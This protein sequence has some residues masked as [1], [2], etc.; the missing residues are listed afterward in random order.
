MTAR[1]FQVALVDGALTIFG[2]V[3]LG[4]GLWA[5][6]RENLG[7]AGTALGGGL[8]LVFGATIHRFESLKGL[9]MEAKTRK[10]DETID[11]AEVALS[12]LKELTELVGANLIK[13]SSSI[14]RFSGAPSIMEAYTLSRQV[15]KTLDGINADHSV[16]QEALEPW[17]KIAAVDLFFSEHEP[18]RRIVDQKRQDLSRAAAQPAAAGA[19]A[20]ALMSR[21][22]EMESY[23]SKRFTEI[24]TWRLDQF[25][26]RL[27]DRLNTAPELEEDQRRLF[28]VAFRRAAEQLDALARTLDFADLAYWRAV[29]RA[30]EQ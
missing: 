8:I 27:F 23:L 1:S 11:K 5:V 28:D 6:W 21:V 20:A 3:L 15:K 24:Q 14:G 4:F 13:L 26:D 30:H 16:I 22:R 19:E 2:V 7:L 12:K 9:G 25:S 29:K 18:L 10:L 17:A